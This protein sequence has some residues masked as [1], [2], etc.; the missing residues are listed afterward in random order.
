MLIK[1]EQKEI[2]IQKLELDAKLQRDYELSRKKREK[3]LTLFNASSMALYNEPGNLIIN[4]SDK[5][6]EFDVAI[7]RSGRRGVGK[8][9]IF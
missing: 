5:G 3:A 7:Q 2:K 9:K 8:M 4:T 1:K 6:Y